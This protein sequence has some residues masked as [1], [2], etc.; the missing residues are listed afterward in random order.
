MSRAGVRHLAK[1][2]QIVIDTNVIVSALRSKRGA[3]FRLVSLIGDERW[4]MN[5]SVPLVF[6]YEDVLKREGQVLTLSRSEVEDVVDFICATANHRTI[7]YLWRPFLPDPHDD[8]ILELAVEA[9]ADFTV[10]YNR[11][12]FRGVG[13]FGIGVVTPAEFLKVIGEIA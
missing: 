4:Q 12:D 7:F 9:N 2:Y 1:I 11:R 5:V 6:E 3:S 10:T 13:R 8:L